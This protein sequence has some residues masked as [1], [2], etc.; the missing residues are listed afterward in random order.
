MDARSSSLGHG[1][2]A[3]T[4]RLRMRL[5]AL[6]QSHPPLGH[7][8]HLRLPA[9]TTLGFHLQTIFNC[10]GTAYFGDL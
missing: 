3:N 6:C 2:S 7:L 4:L 10:L 5:C 8:V 1:P 9:Y